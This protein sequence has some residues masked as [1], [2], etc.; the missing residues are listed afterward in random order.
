MDYQLKR[1]IDR[2][3]ALAEKLDENSIGITQTIMKNSINS[4]KEALQFELISLMLY[5]LGNV[6]VTQDE[7]DMINSYL[8]LDYPVGLYNRLVEVANEYDEVTATSETL[9]LYFI[10]VDNEMYK[11]QKRLE[12]SLSLLLFDVY[13]QLGVK[14][15]EHKD[16]S[17]RKNKLEDFRYRLHKTI[18]ER[19]EF[20]YVNVENKSHGNSGEDIESM[21]L[22]EEQK[23]T[24]DF[25]KNELNELVGLSTVKQDLNSLINLIRIRKIREERGM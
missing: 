19:E 17:S 13:I 1:M 3:F 2:L 22:N 4:T 16:D 7:T 10:M 14:M 20:N 23:E 15:L 5:F 6:Q 9:L 24:I 18:I 25:L 11:K 12:T 8:D 21:N